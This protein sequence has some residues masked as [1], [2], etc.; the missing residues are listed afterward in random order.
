MTGSA[1][2]TSLSLLRG[3]AHD[4]ERLQLIAAG[5]PPQEV[6]IL[7]DSLGEAGLRVVTLR[8][9]EA[10]SPAPSP[11][12][13]LR[14]QGS[15]KGAPIRLVSR[16]RTIEYGHLEW[17]IELSLPHEVDYRERRETYR[18]PVPAQD[19]SAVA[20]LLSTSEALL[21]SVIDLSRVGIGLRLR[22]SVGNPPDED[23]RLQCEVG[24]DESRIRL[25]FSLR[26]QR[27]EGGRVQMGGT[28]QP[29]TPLDRRR[30]DDTVIRLE[31]LWLRQRQSLRQR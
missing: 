17:L 23:D 29:Q 10:T 30:L 12:T 4:A 22:E 21:A 2:A 19:P 26:H 7:A 27:A 6:I 31:R 3:L 20:I 24:R 15:L 8:P 28:I 1:A 18:I 5:L 9:V 25:W 16:L 14:L 13:S 11:G